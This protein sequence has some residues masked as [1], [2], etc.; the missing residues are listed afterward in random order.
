MF[1]KQNA[2][3]P[4]TGDDSGLLQTEQ[5]R[6]ACGSIDGTV[7]PPFCIELA[8]QVIRCRNSSRQVRGFLRRQ[9][10]SGR[11]RRFHSCR[12]GPTT[13]TMDWMRLWN[14]NIGLA[15]LLSET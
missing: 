6:Q 12:D 14:H 11:I 7:E 9:Q 4:G 15:L 2:T 10:G 8:G 13:Q 3:C 5:E 1:V